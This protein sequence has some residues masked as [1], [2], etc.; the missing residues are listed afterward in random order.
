MEASDDIVDLAEARRRLLDQPPNQP[1]SSVVPFAQVR[2]SARAQMGDQKVV[3]LRA[4]TPSARPA[5]SDEGRGLSRSERQAFREI[6]RALGARVE[7]DEE[8]EARS[9]SDRSRRRRQRRRHGGA[10]CQRS[11]RWT[12]PVCPPKTQ[13]ATRSGAIRRNRRR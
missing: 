3:P 10:R 12:A 6:A 11:G 4:A 1:P 8:G 13:A 7:G 5:L 2:G 9:R